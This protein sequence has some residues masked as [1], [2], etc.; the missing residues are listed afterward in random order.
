M[1]EY[2]IYGG[3]KGKSRLEVLSRVLSDS[4]STF[5]NQYNIEE[6]YKCLDLGC[7]GGDVS[8]LI[9]TKLNSKGSI[10]AI[11]IDQRELEL[12]EEERKIRGI[13]NLSF[14]RGDVYQLNSSGEYDLI[15]SRFL[16]SHLNN[17]EAALSNI[18][19]A[20]KPGGLLLLED[21]DFSG[22]FSNP[23]NDAFDQYVRLYQ[24]LLDKR[25]ANA[26]IGKE[27]FWKLE[28]A[29]F[30]QIEVQISQ[31]VFTQGE[32]KLM[33]ELT[34]AG[35]LQSLLEENL[36]SKSITADIMNELIEFG[37]SEETMISLPRIFQLK[38]L[39]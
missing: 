18:K 31:P 17:V 34:F 9:S 24:M 28:E 33:A 13:E 39:K 5:I 7:G 35:I 14:G 3:D 19:D 38:A 10:K 29:G 6:N 23:Q 4:T 36:V 15:Y 32:G 8:F 22:H 27:L 37:R 21:T 11:D 26:N 12:A 30:S 20:L 2:T 16:L 25:G 1:S